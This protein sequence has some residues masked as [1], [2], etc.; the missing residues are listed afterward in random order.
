MGSALCG[1]REH[2]AMGWR[3]SHL[4]EE[5][6]QPESQG[7]NHVR[8]FSGDDRAMRTVVYWTPTLTLTSLVGSAVEFKLKT[9]EKG[10]R[11]RAR[12]GKIRLGRPPKTAR[13]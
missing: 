2:E 12:K 8:F 3:L 7:E 10:R 11:F 4:Y 1:E 6:S 5:N 9:L 13:T